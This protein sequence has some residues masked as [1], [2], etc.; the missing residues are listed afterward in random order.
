[1]IVGVLTVSLTWRDSVTV[2]RVLDVDTE[3]V[4]WSMVAEGVGV[5]TS[6]R[7]TVVTSVVVADSCTVS[8]L[9]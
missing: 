9:L 8:V 4:F 5:D 1:M 2:V 3:L 7:D 6:V